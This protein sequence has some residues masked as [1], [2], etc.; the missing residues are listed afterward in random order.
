MRPPGG[1]GGLF[2]RRVFETQ[3]AQE[4]VQVVRVNA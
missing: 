2:V 1:R 4:A 3:V